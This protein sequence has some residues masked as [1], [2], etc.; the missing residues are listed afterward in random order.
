MT[1]KRRRTKAISVISAN[2]KK[3]NLSERKYTA[4]DRGSKA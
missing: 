4:R 1:I 2:N 3:K